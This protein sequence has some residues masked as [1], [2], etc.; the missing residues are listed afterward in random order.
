MAGFKTGYLLVSNI[1]T[2][3]CD[4]KECRVIL[5]ADILKNEER[6]EVVLYQNQESLG[7]F[8]IDYI[9]KW[10][11]FDKNGNWVNI[12]NSFIAGSKGIDL[13][14]KNYQL[15][16]M[17]LEEKEI[18]NKVLK[19]KNVKSYTSLEQNEVLEYDFDKNGSKEKIILASNVS[20]RVV[21][22][23]LFAT[24]IVI[25]KNKVSVLYFDLYGKDDSHLVPIYNI[26]NVINL[27]KNKEDYVVLLKGYFSE[28]GSP[29]SYI[30]K[31]DKKFEEIS[32][33]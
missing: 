4:K 20:D 6:E 25:V 19:E 31:V 18:L 16:E 17:S 11:F 1:G 7:E 12:Q 14:V 27:F 3:Q 24:V 21:D 9:N 26:K 2:Y 29:E 13:E 5:P 30:Y 33:K 8:K 22:E 15:R 10:N 23:Q 28:V 32:V